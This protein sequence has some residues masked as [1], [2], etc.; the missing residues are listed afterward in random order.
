MTG[1]AEFEKW[2]SSRP[3][4]IQDLGRKYPPGEYKIKEGAP[5]ALTCP[6]TIVSIISYNE[7]GTIQVRV[8]SWNM[9]PQAVEHSNSMLHPQG[10]DHSEIAHKA[11]AAYVDPAHLI[12]YNPTIQ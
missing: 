11:I 1:K 10:R 12:P 7:N 4:V 8:D 9:L 6:G 2:L 5:Y 3:T